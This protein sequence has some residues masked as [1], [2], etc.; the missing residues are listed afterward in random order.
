[1]TKYYEHQEKCYRVEP[2]MVESVSVAS[3]N[4]SISKISNRSIVDFVHR[5]IEDQKW[6]EVGEIYYQQKREEAYKLLE[7]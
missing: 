1:M 2:E 5:S 7:T 4:V 3:D 6:L